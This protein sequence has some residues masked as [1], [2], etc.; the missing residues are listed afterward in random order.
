MHERADADEA[1]L[2]ISSKPG[3]GTELRLSWTQ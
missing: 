2:K 1:E 3:E